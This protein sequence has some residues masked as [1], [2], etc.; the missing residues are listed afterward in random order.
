MKA[1]NVVAM[2]LLI[3][4]GLNWGM[5]GLFKV[6]VVAAIFGGSSTLARIVYV[7]V[8]LCA[9]WGIAMLAPLAR[10]SGDHAFARD[11]RA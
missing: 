4:G 11:V 6:D 10:G 5:V 9:L 8:G 7:I 2:I 3:I 1:I